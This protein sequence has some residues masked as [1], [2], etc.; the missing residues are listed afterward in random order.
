M[1]VPS[2]QLR[3]RTYPRKKREMANKR[4]PKNRK[5]T[6]PAD[7][8]PKKPE[9]ALEQAL[10]L[11]AEQEAA[12][13]RAAEEAEKAE[14]QAHVAAHRQREEL[15]S[16][17]R[18][19]WRASL[20]EA[21]LGHNPGLG[22]NARAWDTDTVLGIPKYVDALTSY[23]TVNAEALPA[24]PEEVVDIIWH[25][26]VSMCAADQ[27]EAEPLWPLKSMGGMRLPEFDDAYQAEVGGSQPAADDQQEPTEDVPSDDEPA[28][29]IGK[30]IWWSSE[31][32]DHPNVS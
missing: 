25:Q 26:F 23:S 31:P 8:P 11:A 16:R 21:V 13:K 9:T 30:Y 19:Q 22:G 4:R 2:S 20:I 5:A 1:I 15:M 12:D 18:Q 17:R 14:W 24:L 27:A 29:A 3:L 6:P 32:H 10:R 7:P 28:P